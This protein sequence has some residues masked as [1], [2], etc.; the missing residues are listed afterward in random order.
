MCL[1]PS[2]SFYQNIRGV[3]HT[4]THTQAGAGNTPDDLE[5]TEL[6]KTDRR[7]KEDE[8]GKINVSMRNKW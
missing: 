2:F 8:R 5:P 3:L 1:S 4:H 6:F 7:R